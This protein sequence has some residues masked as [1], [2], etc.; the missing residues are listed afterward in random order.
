MD[1]PH[2]PEQLATVQKLIERLSPKAVDTILGMIDTLDAKPDAQLLG[3]VEF[4]L[5]DLA[6]LLATEVHQAALNERKKGATE[7]PVSSVLTAKSPTH[8]TTMVPADAPSKPST[9]G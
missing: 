3:L 1:S 8:D 5:R 6:H 4:Q 9:G 7:A 2:T